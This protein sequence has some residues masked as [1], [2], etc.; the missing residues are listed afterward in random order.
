[1]A[2]SQVRLCWSE[3]LRSSSGYRLMAAV[4]A[5]FG[6]AKGTSPGGNQRLRPLPYQ[7]VRRARR[8]AVP[9]LIRGFRPFIPV[10]STSG[11]T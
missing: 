3:V 10:S 4:P 6:H 2:G 1:M 8:P 5:L 9:G 11:Y 7:G